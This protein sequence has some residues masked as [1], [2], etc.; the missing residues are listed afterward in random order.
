MTRIKQMENNMT[1]SRNFRLDK[2]NGKFMG[3]CSGIANYT[4]W[5][6]NLIRIGVVLA[7]VFAWGSLA[8]V[9]LAVGLIA[10]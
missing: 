5:D 3:V 9:Y 8:L 6:V 1:P 2:V 7:T 4:G 10:D